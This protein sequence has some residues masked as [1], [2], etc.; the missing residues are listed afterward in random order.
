MEWALFFLC[1]KYL[2]IVF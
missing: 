2:Y 1:K